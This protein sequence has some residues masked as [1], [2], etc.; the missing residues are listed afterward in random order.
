[1]VTIMVVLRS[2]EE[3]RKWQQINDILKDLCNNKDKLDAI[4]DL[5]YQLIWGRY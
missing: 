5:F 1:M 4:T 2:V 3:Q